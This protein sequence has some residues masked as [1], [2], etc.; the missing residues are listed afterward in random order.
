[1]QKKMPTVTHNGI[2]SQS[3]QMFAIMAGITLC[4]PITPLK[5]YLVVDLLRF[6]NVCYS[7]ICDIYSFSSAVSWGEE[8]QSNGT[9]IDWVRDESYHI[10]LGDTYV[11]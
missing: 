4:L 1:M 5:L 2:F 6:C 10:S 7:N 8:E 11:R 3:E 9:G